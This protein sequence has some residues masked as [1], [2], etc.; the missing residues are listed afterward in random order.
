MI[1]NLYIDFSDHFDQITKEKGWTKSD[2]NLMT[3]SEY[4]DFIKD[5]MKGQEK[6]L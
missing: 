1:W 3:T 4:I 2:F 5:W 6:L